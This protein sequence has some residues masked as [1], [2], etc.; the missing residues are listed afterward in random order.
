MEHHELCRK[1]FG[2]D[3]MKPKHHARH[4]LPKQ[5]MLLGF[6]ID[7][8]A[9]ERKHKFYKSHIGLHRFDPVAQ[10]Q[11]GQFSHMVLKQVMIPS[12]GELAKMHFSRQAVW[13]SGARCQLRCQVE[14]GGLHNK[15]SLAVFKERQCQRAMSCLVIIPA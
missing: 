12:F 3:F 2:Y 13:A 1:A 14:H 5:I 8:F 10:N 6:A 11:N 15:Q 9:C 4:H 7:A